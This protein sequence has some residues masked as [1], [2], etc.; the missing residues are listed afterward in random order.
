MT[1]TLDMRAF[2]WLFSALI[3]V[4]VLWPAAATAG[5]SLP[6]HGG[7]SRGIPPV[8]FPC[9]QAAIVEMTG[10]ATEEERQ[11]CAQAAE[12]SGGDGNCGSACDC[13]FLDRYE[14]PTL[15][16]LERQL[17]VLH[18]LA[19]EWRRGWPALLRAYLNRCD[20]DAQ[21][22]QL[23][24]DCLGQMRDMLLS[25]LKNDLPDWYD[26]LEQA[27]NPSKQQS[28]FKNPIRYWE[29]DFMEEMMPRLQTGACM[30]E[31]LYAMTPMGRRQYC[32]DAAQ[33]VHT[34][35]KVRLEQRIAEVEK[36]R[37]TW[38]ARIDNY[39]AERQCQCPSAA[40][41]QPPG[42]TEGA[43]GM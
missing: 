23:A 28:C 11:A 22:A 40:R 34:N 38:K 24:K 7:S 15:E 12:A 41:F 19:E 2:A 42:E 36:L 29:C 20:N 6:G 9:S 5:C 13:E 3:G 32:E 27:V 26:V 39:V 16:D 8:S 21:V 37:D 43:A 1:S 35:T 25:E 10:M 33:K 18:R 17:D 31:T 14:I 4:S 30:A